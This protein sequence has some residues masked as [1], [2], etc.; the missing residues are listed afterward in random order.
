MLSRRKKKQ[1][2]DGN[3]FDGFGGGKFREGSGAGGEW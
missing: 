1:K 2:K 3:E